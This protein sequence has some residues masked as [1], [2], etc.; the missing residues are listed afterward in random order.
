MITGNLS[1]D[2]KTDIV[3]IGESVMVGINQTESS[4]N[5]QWIEEPRLVTVSSHS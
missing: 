5:L 2:Q 4:I 1:V 3:P